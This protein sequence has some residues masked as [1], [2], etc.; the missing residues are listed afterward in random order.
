[1]WVTGE[2][3]EPL[4]NTHRRQEQQQQEQEEAA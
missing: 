2:V 4:Y 3:Y 1:L